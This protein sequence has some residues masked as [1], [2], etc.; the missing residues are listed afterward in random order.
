M[1]FAEIQFSRGNLINMLKALNTSQTLQLVDKKC[2]EI[3]F[4]KENCFTIIC[5]HCEL[6]TFNFEEYLLHFKNVHLTTCSSLQSNTNIE[7]VEIKIEG[8]N[9]FEETVDNEFSTLIELQEVP[10]SN[11]TNSSSPFVTNG[12][13]IS[14][15]LEE[16]NEWLYDEETVRSDEELSNQGSEHMPR[17]CSVKLSTYICNKYF[18]SVDTQTW[19]TKESNCSGIHMQGMF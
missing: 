7:T 1:H 13:I 16:R 19:T 6:K 4:R 2:A 10:F 12:K 9:D 3:F 17:V 8:G 11:S 18:I 14:D 15:A 5:T